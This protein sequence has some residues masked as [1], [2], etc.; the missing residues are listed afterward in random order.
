MEVPELVPNVQEKLVPAMGVVVLTKLTSSGG[1]PEVADAVNPAVRAA[2][3]L[4]PA[5]AASKNNSVLKSF[6]KGMFERLACIR[7]PPFSKRV[8]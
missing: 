5:N 7:W 2:A 3:S 8:F 6:I 1:H 4:A